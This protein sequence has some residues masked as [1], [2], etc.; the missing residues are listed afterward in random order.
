MMFGYEN[1]RNHPRFAPI[2]CIRASFINIPTDERGKTII[3]PSSGE[4]LPTKLPRDRKLLS[5]DGEGSNETIPDSRPSK[6]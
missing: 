4:I 6:S 5:S 3:H 2:C 1:A